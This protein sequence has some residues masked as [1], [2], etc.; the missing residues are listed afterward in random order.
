MTS[1]QATFIFLRTAVEDS[2][3]EQNGP[4]AVISLCFYTLKASRDGLTSSEQVSL[5]AAN[6]II[7]TLQ[8]F[9]FRFRVNPPSA[10]LS[11]FFSENDLMILKSQ[12]AFLS[13]TLSLFRT[14][15]SSDSF[16]AIFL[17]KAQGC[18]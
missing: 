18:K 3:Y 16:L 11:H 14:T 8:G 4:G 12:R 17:Q 6:R 7:S 1:Q 2:F 9:R 15:L 5:R 13:T 10:L